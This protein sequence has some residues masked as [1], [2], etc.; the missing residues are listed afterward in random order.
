MPP[1]RAGGM[2]S[3]SIPKRELWLRDR[4]PMG[5]IAS[6]AEDEAM[7]TIFYGMIDKLVLA[8]QQLRRSRLWISIFR[9]EHLP[10]TE[11]DYLAM[12]RRNFFVHI[13]PAARNKKSFR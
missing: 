5:A 10:Q 4:F 8:M 7:N 13:L 9:R 11:T 1:V 2:T 12:N 6:P 3:I